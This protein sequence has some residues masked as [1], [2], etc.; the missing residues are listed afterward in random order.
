MVMLSNDY[1]PFV[2]V[3]SIEEAA[4]HDNCD[5]ALAGPLSTLDKELGTDGFFENASNCVESGKGR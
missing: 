5:V 2:S 4:Q 1:S 3:G